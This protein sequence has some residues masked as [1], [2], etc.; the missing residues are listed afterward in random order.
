MD[1]KPL[2][3]LCKHEVKSEITEIKLPI[4]QKKIKAEISNGRERVEN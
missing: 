3:I 1:V 4:W 2:F